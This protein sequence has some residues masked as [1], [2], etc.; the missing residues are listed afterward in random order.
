MDLQN[1][2]RPR[3]FKEPAPFELIAN[4]I[5]YSGTLPLSNAK[6]HRAVSMNTGIDANTAEFDRERIKK[7]VFELYATLWNSNSIK[8]ILEDESFD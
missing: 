7:A 4:V 3:L 1:A 8:V 5:E 2:G 6:I